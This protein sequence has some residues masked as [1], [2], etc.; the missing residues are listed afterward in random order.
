MIAVPSQKIVAVHLLEAS[1]CACSKAQPSIFQSE[2]QQLQETWS[3]D[4]ELKHIDEPQRN[5]KGM[6][7]TWRYE[8]PD[9]RDAAVKL[10]RSHTPA[11]YTLVRQTDSELSFARWNDTIAIN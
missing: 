11:G 10:F 4:A 9:G 7:E 3:G 2:A 5:T 1:F 6:Q 8:F